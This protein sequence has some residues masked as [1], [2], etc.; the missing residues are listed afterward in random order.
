[1]DVSPLPEKEATDFLT[2]IDSDRHDLIVGLFE[3]A[4]VGYGKLE[5]STTNSNK[6]L[7]SV[8]EVFVMKEAR[9][10]GVGE[11]MM[12]FMIQRSKSLG[13]TGIDGFA[14]P[15]DRETKNFFESQGMVA[16]LIKV[17]SPLESD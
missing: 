1:M 9:S 6:K 12:N 7:A 17:Y 16:R 3:E 10:V 5:Y 15:G 14:L 2:Y 11:S 4:I 13:C 8:K